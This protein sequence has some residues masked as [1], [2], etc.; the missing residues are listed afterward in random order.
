M[1]ILKW[2]TPRLTASVRTKRITSAVRGWIGIDFGS[3][4]LKLAQVERRGS[5]YRIAARWSLTHV[6]NAEAFGIESFSNAMPGQISNLKGLKQLFSGR[7]CAAVFPMALVEHRLLEIPRGSAG[8][9]HRM[10]GEELAAELGVEPDELAF[11]CWDGSLGE[12]SDAD[13]ARTLVNSVPKSLAQ[14]LG[15]SLLNIGLECQVLDGVPCAL[16]RAVELNNVHAAEDAVLAV[17]L[18]YTLPVVVLV[19]SGRPLFARTLRGAG[20][21]SMMQALQ[22][23]LDLSSDECQQ[24]LVR[25]GVTA[26]GQQP[27]L[28][29]GRTMQI[30]AR[31]LQDLLNEIKRTAD[32]ISQNFRG[33]KPQ[34]VCLFGGGAAI[35]NLPEHIS[36]KLD[37][38][39]TPWGL[40]GE[41]PD[42]GDALFGLAAGLSAIAW[43][44]HAC[45]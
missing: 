20:L 12:Q 33:S 21:Q 19:K 3:H 15:D 22:T 24:L 37:L 8:E 44:D 13:V 42:P 2:A 5:E 9:Q 18:S 41:S 43:E 35:K 4:G 6:G 32:Y 36:H 40:G 34:R 38:P 29:T 31:P 28:A 1:S 30:I 16:A 26:I 23:S 25:Y 17:D 27:T 10:A 11:D 45:S 14:K 39:T 7:R